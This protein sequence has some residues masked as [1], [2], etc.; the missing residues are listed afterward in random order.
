MPAKTTFLVLRT[1]PQRGLL[2]N[3]LLQSEAG[4][5]RFQKNYMKNYVKVYH[6]A[7]LNVAIKTSKTPTFQSCFC[8]AVL[9]LENIVI[10]SRI[11]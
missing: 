8:L 5:N 6:P 9:I 3:W 2:A 1:T 10:D 4:K 7:L 11:L